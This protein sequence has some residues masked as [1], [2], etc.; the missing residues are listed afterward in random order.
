MNGKG[1]KTRPK[2][3]TDEQFEKN[4][5]QIQWTK[6]IKEEKKKEKNND[7]RKSK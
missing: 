3:I 1:S 2:S 5:E 6:K 4:W 7:T